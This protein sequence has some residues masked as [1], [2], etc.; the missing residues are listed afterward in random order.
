M[1]KSFKV[2]KDTITVTV[3]VRPHKGLQKRVRYYEKDA[4]RWLAEE[5]PKL[6]IGKCFIGGVVRN[7]GPIEGEWIF[8]IVKPAVK[9]AIKN[10]TVAKKKE[11]KNVKTES[12][13][14]KDSGTTRKT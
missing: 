10:K 3:K 9:K 12:K 5:Y 1:Q 8:Q 4:R 11:V 6:V 2:A 13:E 7:Y 14:V